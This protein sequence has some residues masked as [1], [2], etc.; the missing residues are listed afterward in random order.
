MSSSGTNTESFQKSHWT[1]LA[2]FCLVATSAQLFTSPHSL[3]LTARRGYLACLQS[4]VNGRLR[5]TGVIAL[6]NHDAG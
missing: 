6:G 5:S 2:R 4:P 3:P 1:V